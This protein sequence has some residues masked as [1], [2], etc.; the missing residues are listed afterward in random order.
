MYAGV[1]YYRYSADEILRADGTP[2]GP[3]S[4]QSGSVS[5]RAF[6]PLLVHVSKAKIL[7][8][9]Y[10]MMLVPALANGSLDAPVFGV[11]QGISTGA[12]DLYVVPITLGWHRPRADVTAAFGF[13]A[14]T[15]RYTAGASDNISK[16]MWSYELSGGTTLFLDPKKHWSAS[17][18][19]YWETHA[20]KGGSAVTVGNRVLSTGVTVGDIVTLEG[21]LGRAFLGGA[22]NIGAAYYAQWKVTDDHFGL[23]L[24]LPDGSPLAKHR[25]YGLGPDLTLPIATPSRLIALVNIR[26]LWETGAR[27]KTQGQTLAV[28]TTFPVPSVKLK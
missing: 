5:L 14:P 3:G 11:Q 15:G 13:Y 24:N 7:G 21:G 19:G 22:V 27:V 23:T 16:N 17:T 26:Y 6:A 25:V 12:A 18:S 2:I 9:N 1:L 4:S 28:T 20:A 10:G 8:A